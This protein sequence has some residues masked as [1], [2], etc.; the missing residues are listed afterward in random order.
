VPIVLPTVK[1]IEA[2]IVPLRHWQSAPCHG[3]KAVTPQIGVGD[4]LQSGNSSTTGGRFWGEAKSR[5]LGSAYLSREEPERL[6]A[7]VDCRAA[8]DLFDHIAGVT[9][10]VFPRRR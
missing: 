1:S 5:N 2:E 6:F 8:K 7:T 4:D 9:E 10:N 3:R